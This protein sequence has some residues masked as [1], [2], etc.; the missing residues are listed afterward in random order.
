M[1]K[2]F[3]IAQHILLQLLQ[4][5]FLLYFFTHLIFLAT[6][7]RDDR[8]LFYLNDHLLQRHIDS[9]ALLK[10]MVP[11]IFKFYTEVKQLLGC[12]SD[13]DEITKFLIKCPEFIGLTSEHFNVSS[14]AANMY[15]DSNSMSATNCVNTSLE[16]LLSL[17]NFEEKLLDYDTQMT[18]LHD[19]LSVYLL[20]LEG[21]HRTDSFEE[22]LFLVEDALNTTNNART[23]ISLLNEFDQPQNLSKSA[24]M[25]KEFFTFLDLTKSTRR[26][27]AKWKNNWEN[28]C[29]WTLQHTKDVKYE[30]HSGREKL[31]SC[32]NIFNKATLSIRMLTKAYLQGLS[33]Y[34]PTIEYAILRVE[35]YLQ[36]D[37][38]KFSLRETFLSVT[39][40]EAMSTIRSY[41]PLMK[42]TQ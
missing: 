38:P 12:D 39:F 16:L 17:E 5:S 4:F 19:V 18:E 28:V 23:T 21:F 22:C 11:V 42:D 24:K 36:H 27:S 35:K 13:C 6:F 7:Q 25:L 1:Q 32:K 14:T 15:K 40:T 3:T 9:F 29:G 34:T 30:I 41:H 10:E 26:D 31:L 2:I 37:I 33:E 20:F 8:A